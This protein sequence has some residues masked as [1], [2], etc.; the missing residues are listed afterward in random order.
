MQTFLLRRRPGTDYRSDG[1]SDSKRVSRS[2]SGRR[3]T[4]TSDQDLP[5]SRMCSQGRISKTP[6]RVLRVIGGSGC[7]TGDGL[8]KRMAPQVGL[9]PTFRCNSNNLEGNGRHKKQR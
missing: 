5:P 4:D 9:E 3:V 8:Q 6:K 1:G 2:P 7:Q